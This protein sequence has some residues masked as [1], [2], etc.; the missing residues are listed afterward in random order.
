VYYSPSVVGASY[1]KLLGVSLEEVDKRVRGESV[2]EP[3]LVSSKVGWCEVPRRVFSSL[4]R[5]PETENWLEV[6]KPAAMGAALSAFSLYVTIHFLTFIEVAGFLFARC[7]TR[8][9]DVSF[10]RAV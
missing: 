8:V 9:S 10:N 1:F 7:S 3:V 6:V 4:H 2:E 5:R